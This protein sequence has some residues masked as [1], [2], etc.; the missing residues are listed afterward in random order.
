MRRT[1]CRSAGAH[2]SIPRARLET[3]T[4]GHRAAER[5]ASF[6]CRGSA[7]MNPSELAAKRTSRAPFAGLRL[8]VRDRASQGGFTLIELLVVLVL[9]AVAVGVVGVSAQAYLERAR[10]HQTVLDIATQLR[11]ARDL[12]LQEGRAVIVSYAPQTREMGIDGHAVLDVAPALAIQFK[13]LLHIPTDR[14]LLG[15]PLFVFDAD[16]RARGG[17]LEVGRGAQ[18]VRFEINWL[19]GNIRQSAV[20]AS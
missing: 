9:A 15:E 16:G 20:L 14:A 5:L 6:V 19:L 18:G 8:P 13:P 10:Y 2:S 11:F 3:C 12:S 1:A 4:R 17:L 7:A